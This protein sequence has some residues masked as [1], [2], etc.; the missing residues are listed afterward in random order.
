MFVVNII[1]VEEKAMNQNIRYITEIAILTAMITVLGAIKIP[2]IIPGI[3]FQLSAPLAVA[4]CAVF[5]FKKYIISGCLSSLIG[6]ALG[7]QSILNVMIAM[8]FRLIVGLILWMCQNHMIGIMISG[9]IASALARLSLS[10]Y[11]GKAALPMIALAVPGMIFTVIMAPVFVKV[12]RKI[13][14]QVPAQGG[15]HEKGGHHIS[16]AERIVKLEEVGAIAQSLADRALYHSKGTADFI[17]ITVDV[18][19]SN[20]ITYIDCLQVEEHRANTIA[21]A[22]QLAIELLQG[23]HITEVAIQNAMTFLKELDSSM[24]G[25]MLVDAT[26]G[27]RI[28]IGNRGVRVSHMDSFDSESLGDNEHM[29]EALV[30]ASKVQSAEGIVGELCWS[31]DPDYTVGYVACNGIYHRIPKMKEL[32]SHIGGRV[33]FV[34]SEIDR[35]SVIEYLEKAPVLVQRRNNV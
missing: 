13:H 8:Q 18:I 30:L 33:F 17:N 35:E 3:E 26:T 29:R 24:R 25:A 14:S 11:I 16:G 7:T 23:T 19:P 27:K 2:N 4:I 5:G 28:D 21:E 20:E 1:Y 6:L 34:R 10:L 15:P 32:G 12:F 31:D 9:P 22:H